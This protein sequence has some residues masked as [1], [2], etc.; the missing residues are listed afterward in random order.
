M[1]RQV[2]C[3]PFELLSLNEVLQNM[4]IG[5]AGENDAECSRSIKK[6]ALLK[7]SES[8]RQKKMAKQLWAN[9]FQ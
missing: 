4:C 9:M 5:R 1:I 3:A 7:L 6:W 2:W 8:K